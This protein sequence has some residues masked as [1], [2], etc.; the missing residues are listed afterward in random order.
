[1]AGCRWLCDVTAGRCATTDHGSIFEGDRHGDAKE[2]GVDFL[3][4]LS[5]LELGDSNFRIHGLSFL[6]V[7][8]RYHPYVLFLGTGQTDGTRAL[9]PP[10]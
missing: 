2:S 5:S 1:M 3:Q 4:T 6:P 9:W 10:C 7:T 8:R